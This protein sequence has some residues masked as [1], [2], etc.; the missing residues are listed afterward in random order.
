MK[1]GANDI[2]KIYLGADEVTKVYYGSDLVYTSALPLWTP[3]EITTAAWYDA[4]DAATI[5]ES[6]GSVS[7]WDDKSGNGNNATQGAGANQP[8]TG[9]DTINGVN[10]IDFDA[11]AEYM[12][13]SV[14]VAGSTMSM[15]MVA[16]KSADLS[17]YV[18][19][20]TG[21]QP[22]F[23]SN[24]SS[25]DFEY[26]GATPRITLATTTTTSASILEAVSTSGGT[27][28]TYLDGSSTGSVG[29]QTS[30]VGKSFESLGATPGGGSY[31]NGQI[32]EVVLM[33]TLATTD[34]RQKIEGYLAWKWGLE[35]GLPI[36]HP[37]KSAA[38]T[39]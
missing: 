34:E 9:T 30:F 18:I 7:Q 2:D 24:W 19:S 21:S 4:D 3:D 1:I 14:S 38:P 37:Y 33:D 35:D 10:A 5:T 36:G 20:M 8:T 15:F 22:A 25:K 26:Y 29:G 27:T 12:N 6:G 13:M 11:F 28:D 32:G 17:R 39:L 23:L 16:T 31:F